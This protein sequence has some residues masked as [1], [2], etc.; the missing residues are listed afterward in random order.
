MKLFYIISI[1]IITFSLTKGKRI[2]KFYLSPFNKLNENYTDSNS[3]IPLEIQG[4]ISE[5]I[6]GQVIVGDGQIVEE[7]IEKEDSKKKCK[8]ENN[9]LYIFSKIDEKI[10]KETPF[11]YNEKTDVEFYD[12]SCHSKIHYCDEN[13]KISSD[14]S[15]LLFNDDEFEKA[16]QQLFEDSPYLEKRASNDTPNCLTNE[17]LFSASQFASDSI[18]FFVSGFSVSSVISIL[19]G[20]LK[21]YILCEISKTSKDECCS[22]RQVGGGVALPGTWVDGCSTFCNPQNE[23]NDLSLQLLELISNFITSG[24]KKKLEYKIKIYSSVYQTTWDEN[25]FLT[26]LRGKTVPIINSSRVK[27]NIND[28]YQDKLFDAFEKEEDKESKSNVI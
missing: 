18:D 4:N 12:D 16:C 5:L 9:R 26:F 23:T 1:L 14:S 8:L 20:P 24:L 3:V 22:P 19:I 2:S 13:K 6:D 25:K 27:A 10:C 15:V 17:F 28:N 11:Y 21:N 7:C